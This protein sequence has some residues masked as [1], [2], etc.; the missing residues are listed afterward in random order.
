MA[1]FHGK[2]GEPVVFLAK[3]EREDKTL[4]VGFRAGGLSLFA[5][6]RYD[7]QSLARG[8]FAAAAAL[9]AARRLLRRARRVG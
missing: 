1:V 7:L 5:A 3:S 6:L 2:K 9:A 8:L 4:L